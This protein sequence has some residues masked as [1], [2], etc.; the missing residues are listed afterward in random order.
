MSLLTS[1]TL[2]FIERDKTRQSIDKYLNSINEEKQHRK[3]IIY[4]NIANEI[5]KLSHAKRKQVGAILV[6]NDCIIGEGYNGTPHGFDNTCETLNDENE[7]VTKPEVLHA[8]SNVISKL[9]RSTNSSDGST[10]YVTLSP[11]FECSKLIIQSGIIRLVFLE[12][13]RDVSGLI[14]L[15]KYGIKIKHLGK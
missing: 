3:D 2:E 1:S 9:A 11:C 6:K 5:S 13:Y 15:N 7:L 8:E 14:L 12:E 4:M 10:L